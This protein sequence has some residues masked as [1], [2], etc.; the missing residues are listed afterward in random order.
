MAKTYRGLTL[1]EI[2]GVIDHSVLKPDATKQDIIDGCEVARRF[3]T[4]T[5][6]IRPYDVPLAAELL[7]GSGV[8]VAT[9]IGFPH[10]TTTTGTKVFEA[11]EAIDNGA[12]ELDMVLNVS[13]LISGDYDLVRDDIAAVVEAA[14][15]KLPACSIKVIFETA[16]LTPELIV[17][18]CELTEQA[19]ADYVKTSTGFASAGANLEDVRLMKRTVGDR[20]KVKSSGG[21]KTLDQLIDFIEAGVSRSGCSAT[22]QVVSEFE[23]K[24][25]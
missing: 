18:A 22:I 12:N 8:G 7:K 3:Q 13:A 14:R 2:T 5:L 19:G 23:Q 11:R 15:H 21:V 24:A 17:K 1:S 4:A 10:G 25:K 6:C 20:L 9:V 16:L